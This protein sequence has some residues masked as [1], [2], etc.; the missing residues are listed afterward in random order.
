MSVR[1]CLYTPVLGTLSMTTSPSG[2]HITVPFAKFART[3]AIAGDAIDLLRSDYF[4]FCPFDRQLTE[5]G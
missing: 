4:T 3:A 2:E 5:N 1:V